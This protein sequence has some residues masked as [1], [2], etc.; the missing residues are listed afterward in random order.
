METTRLLTHNE[1]DSHKNAHSSN[2]VF[3]VIGTSAAFEE[4]LVHTADQDTAGGPDLIEALYEQYHRTLDNPQQSLATNRSLHTSPPEGASPVL[5]AE[6]SATAI[7]NVSIETLL[8]RA[9]LLEDEF[10]PL[11]KDHALDLTKVEPVPEVLRL[12]ASAEYLAAAA[13]RPASLPPSLTRREHHLPGV[14]SPLPA[15]LARTK[16]AS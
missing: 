14:D 9:G 8:S 5:R 1:T 3:S 15:P 12:F 16:H 13:R 4:S 6:P 11:H 7:A 2:V 10:G